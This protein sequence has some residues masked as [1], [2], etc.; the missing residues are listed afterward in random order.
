MST[1][2]Y[3]SRSCIAV[4][5]SLVI[6]AALPTFALAPVVAAAG[7]DATDPPVAQPR[8]PEQQQELDGNGASV[9]APSEGQD[10]RA[11]YQGTGGEAKTSRSEAQTEEKQAVHVMTPDDPEWEQTHQGG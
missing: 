10:V 4:A 8:A 1:N 3:R 6:V 7:D 2:S 11:S 5:R 9:S